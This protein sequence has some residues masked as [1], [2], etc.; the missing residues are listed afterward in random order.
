MWKETLGI[1]KTL[2]LQ[3]IVAFQKHT[4]PWTQKG[5]IWNIKQGNDSLVLG[6]FYAEQL[7]CLICFVTCL[8]QL[9][10]GFEAVRE[11]FIEIWQKFYV[12]W[13]QKPCAY[14]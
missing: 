7:W 9:S 3:Q 6:H 5:L 12:C 4:F 13:I 8:Y 10:T 2:Y 11:T 1:Q 14:V